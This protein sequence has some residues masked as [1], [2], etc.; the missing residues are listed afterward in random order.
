MALALHG[1]KTAEPHRVAE[2][3]PAKHL[4]RLERLVERRT[5][6]LTKANI[7]LQAE[8][9][10][11]KA[12]EK[13]LQESE[14]K[15]LQI[16]D[17]NTTPIFVIDKKHI[18][19]HW[20]KA[21][22]NLTGVC[23]GEMVGT[24]KHWSPFYSRERPV[25]ADIIL[26]N[27]AEE[28]MAKY[29]DKFQKSALIDGAYEAEKF[30]P[31]FGDKWLS[32]TAAYLKDHKGNV[33]GAIET[34]RDITQR[35]QT[36]KKLKERERFFSGVLNDMLTFVAVL[37]PDGEIIFVNNTTLDLIG[38]ELENV[39]GKKFYDLYWWTYSEQAKQ[40]IKKYMELCASGEIID[41]EIQMQTINGL[42]WIT[43]SMHPIYDE[44]GEVEYVVPE[45]RDITR[46]KQAEVQLQQQHSA[47]LKRADE[48]FK[49]FTHMVSRRVK[50]E[51]QLQQHTTEVE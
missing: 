6:E 11:H 38:S 15:L 16:I 13:T 48:E 10:E 4:E 22:E 51:V 36:E 41:T 5:A 33:V 26:Y 18:V 30:L 23:A 25:M 39:R 34:L 43:F 2:E 9:T 14:K 1:M 3:E 37:R 42:I 27:S 7:A 50:A 46:Q 20:N 19:T 21:C 24:K 40:T 17:G 28:G 47:E 35:K 31:D 8:I 32:L 49:R 45:G 29:Y 12:A 44:K